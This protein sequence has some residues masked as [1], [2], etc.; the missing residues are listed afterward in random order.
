M[1]KNKIKNSSDMFLYKACIHFTSARYLLDAF[2]KD[3]IDIDI[4]KTYFELQQCAEKCLKS[5]LSFHQIKF[6]K[7][8]DIEEL[9]ELTIDNEIEL[10]DDLS[11]LVRLT[12]YAVEGRYSI[13]HDDVDDSEN[14]IKLLEQLI[15]VLKEERI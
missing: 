13:I 8:H 5:S 15:I 2:N 7:I 1:D 3:K 10:I 14:Y 12:D 4:E 6:P 11:A 9:I